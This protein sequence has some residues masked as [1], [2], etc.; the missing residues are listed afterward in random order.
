MGPNANKPEKVVTDGLYAYKNAFNKE[1][2]TMKT[3]RTQHIRHIRLA[4]DMNN[5]I[6]ERLHGTKRDREKVMRGL[7]KEET[8]IISMQNIYYNRVRPH[9]AL[10]GK[11]PA[12]LAR[13]GTDVSSY[14]RGT[15]NNGSDIRARC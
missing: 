10:E 8:P 5:N 14:S 6:I 1:F 3:P 13:N 2:Y 4:G 9:Q 11:S 15:W 7:K 12:D